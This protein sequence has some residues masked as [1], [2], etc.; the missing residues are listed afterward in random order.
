MWRGK[1]HSACS[2]SPAAIIVFNRAL[3]PSTFVRILKNAAAS[4]YLEPKIGRRNPSMSASLRQSCRLPPTIRLV[5]LLLVAAAGAA[6]ASAIS[7]S[8]FVDAVACATDTPFAVILSWCASPLTRFLA[9]PPPRA[10]LPHLRR[11]PGPP[12]G[13]DHLVLHGRVSGTAVADFVVVAAVAAVVAA[14]AAAEA[15]G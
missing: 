13:P 2:F 10:P 5:A 1:K 15:D 8:V 9:S 11:L 14:E 7:F 4:M 12:L 6:V 3:A